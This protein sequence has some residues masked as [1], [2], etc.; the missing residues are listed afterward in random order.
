MRICIVT[1]AIG[2]QDYFDYCIP[3]ILQY[4][5]R[6]GCDF[7]Y[8]SE[9]SE[10]GFLVH[11]EKW[12]I[13]NVLDSYEFVLFLDADVYVK[14][15]S[16]NF[17]DLLIKRNCVYGVLDSRNK[18]KIGDGGWGDN[19]LPILYKKFGKVKVEHKDYIN[20]GMF[21]I[22]R[23]YKDVFLQLKELERDHRENF[24]DYKDF[25]EQTSLNYLLRKNSIPVFPLD[26]R[27]N[28]IWSHNPKSFVFHFGG[29]WGRNGRMWWN[30]DKISKIKGLFPHVKKDKSW[31]KYPLRMI[32]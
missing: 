7:K 5:K 14:I 20:S 32:V 15:E 23:D 12:Q 30:Q 3:S 17:Q 25:G 28:D 18:K 29:C 4:A 6:S 1:L 22:H 31:R 9:R 26:I 10:K 11:F 8:I 19:D 24:R 2:N 21:I 27:W 13:A 16:P